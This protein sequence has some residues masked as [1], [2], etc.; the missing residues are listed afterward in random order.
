MLYD[1]AHAPALADDAAVSGRVGH[2]CR[3]HAYAEVL[4]PH[5][6]DELF[7]RLRPQQRH[8]ACG[9]QHVS[10]ALEILLCRHHGVA[11][12]ELRLL[13]RVVRAVA[14]ALPYALPARADDEHRLCSRRFPRGGNHPLRERPARSSMHHLREG[15]FHPLAFARGQ[16]DRDTICFHCSRLPFLIIFFRN[17]ARITRE[18]PG[19]IAFIS[20]HHIKL[21]YQT[22]QCAAGPD[23]LSRRNQKYLR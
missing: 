22:C 1:S 18:A 7:Q 16:Y 4:L 6:I 21:L 20:H 3:E 17:A 10:V 23:C 5:G 13:H 2:H 9:D 8:V 12:A 19:S 15:R 11:G 14:E